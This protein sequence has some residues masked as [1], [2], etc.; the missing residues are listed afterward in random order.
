MH[1]PLND[2]HAACFGS[3]S[4]VPSSGRKVVHSFPE[5]AENLTVATTFRLYV[6]H[7]CPSIQHVSADV[8][9]SKAAGV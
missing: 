2:N 8:S 5:G 6:A 9:E 3:F 4:T 1:G 7:I